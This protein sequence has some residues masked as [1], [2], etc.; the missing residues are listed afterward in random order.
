MRSLL[1]AVACCSLAV[2]CSRREPAAAAPDAGAPAQAGSGPERAT[3]PGGDVGPLYPIEPDAPADPLAQKL[4]AALHELPERRRAAC[5]KASPGAVVVAA[6]TRALSAALR[7]EAATLAS[8]D[9][10][11]CAAAL[12]EALAGCDWV[13]PASPAAPPECAGIVKGKLAAGR[14]CRSSLECEGALRCLGAGSTT[15]GRC[16]PAQ[17]AGAGCGGAI[18]ALAS[19]VREE[20]LDRSHPE[21]KDRCVRHRCAPA[22]AEGAPCRTTAECGEGVQCLGGGAT[23][24]G[25]QPAKTC[26]RAALPSREGEVCLGG[27][28]GGGLSCLR[29]KCTARKAAGAACSEDVECRGGCVKSDGGATGTCGPRCDVR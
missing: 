1:A 22:L 5:C 29:A 14:R 20:Q 26:T 16:G 6:C 17:A 18:D 27:V 28:C 15:T 10:D 13:G 2:A 11:R 4:C 24:G 23:V 21:C 9:V 19:L 12:D 8:A 3:D 7:H 25:G